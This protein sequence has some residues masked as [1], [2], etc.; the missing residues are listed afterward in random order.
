MP[1]IADCLLRRLVRRATIIFA[2]LAGL[3]LSGCSVARLGYNN[4]PELTHWWFDGYV[5]FDA[6][7][8][9]QVRADLH[10][11]LDWHR[12]EELPLL[13]DLLKNMQPSATEPV[14]AKEVCWLYSYLLT[15]VKTVSYEMVPYAAGVVATLKPAQLEHIASEYEKR[16]RDWREEWVDGTSAELGER[17]VKF[18]TERAQ[19]FY[20][21]LG[22]EQVRV[23]REHVLAS[24]FDPAIQYREILR[25]QQDTLQTLRRLRAMSPP[26][27]AQTIQDEL[28]DLLAR[29]LRPPDPAYLQYLDMI[30]AQG[31]EMAA[32]LHN[33]TTSAQ[34]QSLLKTLHGFEADAHIL[35]QQR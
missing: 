8:S 17:R 10:T 7:Q 22:E 2:L 27:S 18:V 13:E 14:A 16:N 21:K 32:A 25:R 34:R 6:A 31:C 5:D 30:V 24:G 29:T 19:W 35:A 15:R 9:R 1:P 33:S 11:L 12:K 4:A 26:A 28:R 23:L 3:A 20:G